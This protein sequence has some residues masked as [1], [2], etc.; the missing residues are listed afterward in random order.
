MCIYIYISIHPKSISIHLSILRIHIISVITLCLQS[1]AIFVHLQL[2]VIPMLF[3]PFL[4]QLGKSCLPSVCWGLMLQCEQPNSQKLPTESFTGSTSQIS[5]AWVAWVV[6]KYVH[7]TIHY[8]NTLNTLHISAQIITKNK[9]L[10]LLIWP[11]SLKVKG[12]SWSLY[13]LKTC[14]QNRFPKRAPNPFWKGDLGRWN[15][16]VMF[17]RLMTK[18]TLSDSQHWSRTAR[19]DPFLLITILSFYACIHSFLGKRQA[20]GAS[21][22]DVPEN[23]CAPV[24]PPE[25]S[26]GHFVPCPPL[27]S[28]GLCPCSAEPTEVHSPSPSA[29]P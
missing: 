12:T 1:L 14:I 19:K 10:Y 27:A 24:N 23:R 3:E 6:Y 7:S 13:M 11:T 5:Q 8:A 4:S 26:T 17:G 25:T 29:L 16:L 20:S 9:S 18:W 28:K 21:I 22:Q 2:M 15:E